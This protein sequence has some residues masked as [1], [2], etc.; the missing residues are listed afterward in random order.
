MFMDFATG[1]E[2]S[3]AYECWFNKKRL[4]KVLHSWGIND[5][6]EFLK[7]YIWDDTEA[8]MQEFEDPGWK[9]KKIVVDF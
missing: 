2:G 1:S 7:N 6:R 9:Y 5:F 4:I 8:I 3:K